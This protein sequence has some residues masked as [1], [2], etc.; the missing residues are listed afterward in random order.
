MR[1]DA[2]RIRGDEHA[3]HN[4]ENYIKPGVSIWGLGCHRRRDGLLKVDTGVDLGDCSV[5]FWIG[6]RGNSASSESE[7]EAAHFKT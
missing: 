6:N 4:V 3:S 2:H 1:M 7:R 5:R